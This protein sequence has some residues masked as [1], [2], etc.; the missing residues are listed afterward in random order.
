MLTSRHGAGSISCMET[1]TETTEFHALFADL[2]AR[3][4]LCG[5]MGND[6][7]AECMEAEAA[8][9]LDRCGDR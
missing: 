7:T 2:L 9:W 4:V 6:H 1:N 3:C 5:G 8:D